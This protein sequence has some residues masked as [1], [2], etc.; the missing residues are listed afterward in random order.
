LEIVAANDRRGV[1]RALL[2][3]AEV[4]A[5]EG[6]LARV[7]LAVFATNPARGFYEHLGFETDALLMS[8]ALRTRT[9]G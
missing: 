2:E 4:W 1:G 3:A 9:T 6:G 5:A 8:K 7:S